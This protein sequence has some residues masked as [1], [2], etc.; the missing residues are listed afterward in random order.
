M[1]RLGRLALFALL[2]SGGAC[3]ER[4]KQTSPA[5]PDASAASRALGPSPSSSVLVLV[6]PTT[7]RLA[8]P[9]VAY[10]GP[11]AGDMVQVGAYCIDRYEA[12][13]VPNEYP[14]VMESAVTAEKWCAD[15][16]KRLCAEDEWERA[17]AG[18]QRFA[19]PYGNTY[20]D[21][22]CA[23]EKTWIVKDEPTITMWPDKPAMGEVTRLYQAEKSGT[24]A[25]CVSGYGAFDMTGNVE[26]WVVSR[27]SVKAPTNRKAPRATASTHVLKGCYWS[28]CYGG[29]K[30]TCTSTNAAH[31]DTFK[32]YETGFRCCQDARAQPQ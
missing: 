24:R 14:L 15:R 28:G 32:F 17:C 5:E 9:V 11:C 8:P 4:S 29:S 22:R 21:A 26:E 7:S 30:P 2:A 19:Y 16:G 3:T 23:D 18:P 6:E 27:A 13:N 31:A 12:P 20:E 25:R 10:A 1:R